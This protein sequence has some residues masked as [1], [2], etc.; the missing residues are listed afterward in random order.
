MVKFSVYLNR[1]VFVMLGFLK[2]LINSQSMIMFI[3]GALL[4]LQQI[5]LLDNVLQV[6]QNS[7]V[8]PIRLIAQINTYTTF[9]LP[10]IYFQAILILFLIH[11]L[12]DLFSFSF[13][14]FFFRLWPSIYSDQLSRL[15]QKI[16]C[17]TISIWIMHTLSHCT[18][19]VRK[20][21]FCINYLL[22]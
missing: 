4:K 9:F 22:S 7:L 15:E 16:W 17:R 10:F 14:F 8:V 21:Y 6:H 3:S 20:H 2:P 11:C 1:R 18:G 5:F 12:C 13:F 19:F